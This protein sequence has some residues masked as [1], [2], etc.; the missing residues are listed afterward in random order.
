MKAITRV[1]DLLHHNLE[2]HPKDEFISG[3]IEGVWKKYSTQAF[4]DT[5]DNLSKGLTTIDIKKGSR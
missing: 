4:I 2:N 1:F 3:K 5:T